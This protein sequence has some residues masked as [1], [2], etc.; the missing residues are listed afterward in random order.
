ML[1]R[2]ASIALASIAA[3]LGVSLAARTAHG[4][5]LRIVSFN[6]W[7]VPTVSPHRAE[8]MTEI[9][10]RVAGLDADFVALQ[11]VWEDDDAARIAPALAAAGLTEQRHFGKRQVGGRGSGLWIASRFPITNERF[12]VFDVGDKPYIHW[13]LDYLSEKGVAVVEIDTPKGRVTVANTH[14]Q[15]TYFFG[16]YTFVQLAQALTADQATRDVT[17]PLIFVGDINAKPRSIV[18]RVLVAKLG[19]TPA[20]RDFGIDVIMARASPDLEPRVAAFERLFDDPVTFETGL[21]R[22]LSDHPCLMVDY[23]FVPCDRCAP[24]AHWADTAPALAHFIEGNESD[25]RLFLTLYKTLALCLAALTGFVAQRTR[26]KRPRGARL[27]ITVSG[28]SF[29]MALAAWMAYVAWSYG[30]FKLDTLSRLRSGVEGV[31]APP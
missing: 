9:A 7:G 5:D 25:T 10:R 29:A 30:P 11:E 22:T 18:S 24:L 2:W 31:A 14:L 16:D 4:A 1:P 3:V 20:S 23:D 12:V 8:R 17:S 26:R 19:L 13:H 28:V 21:R 6:V 15:S 27:A